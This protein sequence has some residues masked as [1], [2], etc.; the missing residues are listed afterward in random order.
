MELYSENTTMLKYILELQVVI[1]LTTKMSL[2]KRY[3]TYIDSKVYELRLTTKYKCGKA[4]IFFDQN[5]CYL[6]GMLS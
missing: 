3:D 2:E 6:C 5:K 4:N 1:S